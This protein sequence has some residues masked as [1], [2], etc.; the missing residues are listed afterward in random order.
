MNRPLRATLLI[1]PL[2]LLAACAAPSARVATSTGTTQA[3][4]PHAAGTVASTPLPAESSG[5]ATGS[6]ALA[7]FQATLESLARALAPSIVQIETSQGLGSGIVY[8]AAGDIVTNAHVVQGASSY[9]VK[10]SDG[11]TF[12]ATLAGTFA[13]NDL[14]VVHASGTTGL[15]PARFADSSQVQVGE[16]VLA[17]GSPFGLSGTVTEGIVSATGRTQSEGNGVTLTDLVQTSALINPGNSGGALV[18]IEGQVIGI[19]TLSGSDSQGRNQLSA[20][21][22]FAIPSNQVVSAARQ[23]V[24]TG[25]VTHTNRAYLGISTRDNSTAGVDVVSVVAGGPAGKAGLQ[26]GWTISAIGGHPVADSNGLTQLLTGYAPG[27]K[28]AVT[29][30]LPDGSTRSVSVTLGERPAQL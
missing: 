28:V 11:R 27:D 18:D 22:G 9:T 20:G 16:V 21:I 10:T 26:A 25:S 23:L 13:G 19:P 30:E 1:L 3:T 17:V 12:T 8:D 24:A 7:Q 2:L 4:T 14:A 6:G 15:K 5:A 29:V